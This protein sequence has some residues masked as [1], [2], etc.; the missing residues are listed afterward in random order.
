MKVLIVSGFLGAG[1]TTFIKELYNRVKKNIVILE[2]EYGQENIDSSILNEKENMNIWELTEGC[3]CCSVKANFATSV[4]AISNTLNPEILIVEPTG[5]GMLSS[6]LENLLKIQYDRIE[7][8]KPITLIDCKNI[9]YY[10]NN[11]DFKEIFIDQLVNASNV[12]ITKTENLNE[13]EIENI[14]QKLTNLNPNGIIEKRHYKNMNDDFFTELLEKN[15]SDFQL[16][17]KKSVNLS[18]ET[19]ALKNISFN[20]YDHFY[21]YMS[22][23]VRGDFGNIERAKGFF[24]IE[25]KWVKFDIVAKEFKIERCEKMPDSKIVIIGTNLQ[26]EKIRILFQGEF[27]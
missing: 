18:L 10:L 11:P 22:A 25:D 3:I 21:S 4:L 24:T 9:D 26:K 8:L 13:K 5:I 6:I 17:S 27:L 1:K 7:I 15:Y 14:V 19:T 12:F 20:S 2:N 16:S 23:F